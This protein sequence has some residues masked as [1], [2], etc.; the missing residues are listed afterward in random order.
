MVIVYAVCLMS[1]CSKETPQKTASGTPAAPAVEQGQ[2]PDGEALY[3]QYCASCHPDGG[4]VNDPKM[5]LHGSAMRANRITT[6]DDVVRIM[7]TPISR[8][9]RFDAAMLP[10]RE[11]RAIGEYVLKTFK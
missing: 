5:N 6:P 4:N 7:R 10:D 11:A 9:I 8:M 1:G 3:K 2:M